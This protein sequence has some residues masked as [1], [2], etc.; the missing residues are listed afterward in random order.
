MARYIDADELSRR[1][2]NDAFETDSDM[3]RWDSGCWIRYKMFENAINDA[4]TAT[5]PIKDKC[6]FCPHCANC[7]VNDDLSIK[8]TEDVVERKRGEWIDFSMSIKGIP[9]EACGECGEW[10]YGM[11]KNFCPNC[12]AYMRGK[13]NGEHD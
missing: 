1:M 8:Q 9:T 6:A 2:Y 5:L 13:K 12:G 11:G 10:S 3:Q 7:D 4:P